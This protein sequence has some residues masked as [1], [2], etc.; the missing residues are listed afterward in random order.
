MYICKLADEPW[1]YG[2]QKFSGEEI[3]GHFYK[4]ELQDI[5]QRES[6]MKMKMKTKNKKGNKLHAN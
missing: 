1:T 2:I 4:K 3:V 5:N 6:K